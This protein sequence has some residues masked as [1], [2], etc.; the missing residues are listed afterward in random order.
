[1]AQP[2]ARSGERVSILPLRE[3]LAETRTSAII[4]AEQLE[5]VRIVL[6]AGKEMR[7]H[8]APG[9]ITVMCI[10]GEIAFRTPSSE[11][12]LLA[13]DFIHLRRMEPH[14]L[15]AVVDSSALLTICLAS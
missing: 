6:M 9:E 7:E 3:R 8:S 11:Q 5:I 1:M 10:E 15:K 12:T 14:A 2:H 4:K 13:G